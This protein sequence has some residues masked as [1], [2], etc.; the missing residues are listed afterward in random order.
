[1]HDIITL[2]SDIAV[3]IPVYIMLEYP[4]GWTTSRNVI[5][6]FRYSTITEDSFMSCTAMG[7][8]QQVMYSNISPF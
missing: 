8:Y 1:V 4:H 5:I 6:L 2:H 3:W 7:L